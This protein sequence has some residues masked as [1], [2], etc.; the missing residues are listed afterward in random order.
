M[1]NFKL[2]ELS[3]DT[4]RLFRAFLIVLTVGVCL[5]LYFISLN[6]SF[7]PDGVV[8]HFSGS[9]TPDEFELSYGKSLKELVLTTHNHV[10]SFSFIFVLLGGIFLGVERISPRLKKFLLVEPFV[11]ILTTFGSMFLIRFVHPSFVYLMILSSVVLYLSYFLMFF[12][13]IRELRK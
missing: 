8:T 6:S 2:S 3:P 5:G 12:Y 9:E 10:I 4:K 1:H 13:S 7:N 11:S